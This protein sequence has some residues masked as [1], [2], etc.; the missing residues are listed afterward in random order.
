LTPRGLQ[1]LSARWKAAELLH[2][3]DF[4]YLWMANA[5]WWQCRWM[6]ELIIGW[7][8][9]ELTDSAGMVALVS[10]FRGAPFL[11]FGPFIGTVVQ[12]V[13]Y[14]WLIVRSQYINMAV[15]G[16]LGL[17]G[18][19]STLAFWQVALGALLI[20]L[21]G[22][23]DWTARRAMI[24]DLIGKERTM[25]AMVLENIPQNISRVLGPFLSGLVLE[26]LGIRW[27]FPV[28]WGFY[29]V[30]LYLV[31]KLSPATDRTDRGTGTASPWQDLREGLRYA[32]NNQRILGVL[33]ITA[34][35]NIFTFPFQSLLP[36][37]ARDV[38][39]QGPQELGIMAASIG[40][41]SFIGA[42]IVNRLKRYQQSGRVFAVGSL[43][44]SVMIMAFALS[45][46]Y[47]LSLLLLFL[48]GVG[49]AGFS[50]MQSSIIL[51]STPDEMRARVMGT[52]VLA[53]GGG[54]LGRLQIGAMATGFGTPLALCMSAGVAAFGVL[55]VTYRLPG[56]RETG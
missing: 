19:F 35:M 1:H 36:V 33:G 43:L 34:F 18:L 45:S 46:S 40:V 41:G 21:G 5:L 42:G 12:R 13:T 52:L 15:A 55:L 25:E 29:M 7:V 48:N 50:V 24:P 31:L 17:L 38:L 23:F 10:A 32:W 28:L 16:A 30:G 22:A 20:G 51:E 4:R 44:S 56:F 11:L 3:D 37:F 49:Q 53:I 39:H 27:C 26:F 9:L 6:E 8:V 2:I 54:P 14:R 47:P